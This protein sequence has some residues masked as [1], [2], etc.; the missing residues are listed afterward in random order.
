MT[1]P[2]RT[3]DELARDVA[4][5]D[6]T[7][8]R[9][10]LAL[11]PDGL[12]RAALD[13]V[14][15]I[16]GRDAAMLASLDASVLAGRA[17]LDSAIEASNVAS[18][19][20][21]DEREHLH[22]LIARS[23]HSTSIDMVDDAREMSMHLAAAGERAL[24]VTRLRDAANTARTMG[25]GA[26]A[27]ELLDAAVA[28][29]E[30]ATG[31]VELELR[32]RRA[33]LATELDA[34]VARE[35]WAEL[36][37]IYAERGDAAE[38]AARARYFQFW[39]SGDDPDARALLDASAREAGT[40]A[41]ATRAAAVRAHLDEQYD[42]SI[43]LDRVAL[44]LARANHDRR[45]EALALLGLAA[46]LSM[47][48]EMRRGIELQRQAIAIADDQG[49]H[50]ASV[51]G[52]LNLVSMLVDDMRPARALAQSD[53]LL[54]WIDRTGLRGWRSE[55]LALRSTALAQLGRIDDAVAT[56]DAARADLDAA[57]AFSQSLAYL[58]H[59]V[60][61]TMAGGDR[62][63]IEQLLDSAVRSADGTGVGYV[64]SEASEVRAMLAATDLDL[65][66]ALELATSCDTA[67]DD[68]K[69]RRVSLLLA[70][71]GAQHGRDDYIEHALRIAGPEA[72][73]DL[74]VDA[75]LREAS[76]TCAA[77]DSTS[78]SLSG[79]QAAIEDWTRC[80]HL[81]N[82]ARARLTLGSLLERRGDRTASEV[83]DQARRE[84]VEMGCR[85]EAIAG[86]DGEAPGADAAAS[87]LLIGLG[88]RERADVM[89][90]FGVRRFADGDVLAGP[91]V[92][93]EPAAYVVRSGQVRLVAKA[94][95]GR[96][97]TIDLLDAGD[98]VGESLALGHGFD[99]LHA[100]AIGEVVVGVLTAP[101]LQRLVDRHPVLGRNLLDLVGARARRSS[102]LAEE[103]AFHSVE[104]R[105][106]R[107]VLEL[108]ERFGNPTLDGLRMVR[109][110]FTQ[111]EL[112]ELVHARRETVNGL[113]KDLREAGVIELRKRR[114]VVLDADRLRA[115]AT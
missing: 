70:R 90:S 83:L 55:A 73:R 15:R 18:T 11:C 31:P 58:Q 22:L 59:A 17:T 82:A 50:R 64:T 89:S 9:R 8:L 63:R 77:Y 16:E 93:R 43:E 85:I 57:P 74:S 75:S 24:A 111:A 12:D 107:R 91:D 20:D 87:P 65:D 2:G 32:E 47:S 37:A 7:F 114:I 102:A 39:A 13:A 100:E 1:G 104:Q 4:I 28:L 95:D 79:L 115:L 67:N 38:D 72:S 35:A 46:S 14:A 53:A 62:A 84:L 110:A 56:A 76:A 60:T 10:V 68:V 42:I 25:E 54:S 106:A 98:V 86:D 6:A 27:L 108:A 112:A 51:L 49:D 45:L 80:G 113:M 94:S 19:L 69:R 92:E 105:F 36:A 23:I 5:D 48:G 33:H 78:A 99:S 21:V 30:G 61:L 44:Q 66:L 109:Y 52:Q 81:Y 88:R 96:R 40:G 71:L 41:W 26:R 34:P 101:V 103:L 29:V 97:M 3:S